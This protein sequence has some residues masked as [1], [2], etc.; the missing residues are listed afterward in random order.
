[1]V[2]LLALVFIAARIVYTV[3]YLADRPS[4]RSAV[5]T[6]AFLAAIGLFVLAGLTH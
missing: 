4:M 2:N 6:L 3:L 1:M 5:W